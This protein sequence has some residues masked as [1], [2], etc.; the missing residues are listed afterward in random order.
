MRY[1]QLHEWLNINCNQCKNRDECPG[2]EYGCPHYRDLVDPSDED[3]LDP[4]FY[5]LKPR[6]P[7]FKPQSI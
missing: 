3:L 6:C 4:G 5:D 1:L 2:Y 7:M